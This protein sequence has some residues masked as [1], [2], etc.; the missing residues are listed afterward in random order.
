MEQAQKSIRVLRKVTTSSVHSVELENDTS[1]AQQTKNLTGN[2]SALKQMVEQPRC[3][4]SKNNLSKLSHTTKQVT[5]E[6]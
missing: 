1:A 4:L 5:E 3:T 6:K 2:R